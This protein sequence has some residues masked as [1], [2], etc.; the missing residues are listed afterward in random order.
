MVAEQPDLTDQ[1]AAWEFHRR[2]GTSVSRATMGRTL[3]LD[4]A[5]PRA[6]DLIDCHDAARWFRHRGYQVG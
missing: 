5:I 3:A 6:M 1:E 2:T 4:A